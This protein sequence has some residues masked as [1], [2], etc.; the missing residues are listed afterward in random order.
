VS[1]KITPAELGDGWPVAAPEEQKG[2]TRP[3]LAGS[4]PVSRDGGRHAPTRLSSSV[5]EC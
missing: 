3:S 2:L 1:Q 5:A 4:A